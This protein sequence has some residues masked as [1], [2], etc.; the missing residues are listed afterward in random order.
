MGNSWSARSLAGNLLLGQTGFNTKEEL[1]TCVSVR[2]QVMEK[3]LI[4]INTPDL[5]VPNMSQYKLTQHIENCVRLSAP[6]PHVFLLVLQPETFTEEH[7]L[8]L[9]RILEYFN[10]RSFDHSLVLLA[11]PPQGASGVRANY[12]NLTASEDMMKKCRG[13]FLFNKTTKP[14]E[15]LER[16]ENIHRDNKGQHVSCDSFVDSTAADVQVTGECG[17]EIKGS[18]H[19]NSQVR[20][21]NWF[22][23]NYTG[24]SEETEND[25]SIQ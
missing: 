4:L 7:N 8:R 3:E 21:K 11:P 14:S 23:N 10:D 15:L 22:Q 13:C 17:L 9:C 1:E 6:G 19:K 5:L 20:R 25:L 16:L 18:I 12:K 2:G 24:T